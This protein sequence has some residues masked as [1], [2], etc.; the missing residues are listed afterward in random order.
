MHKWI[1]PTLSEVLALSKSTLAN[2]SDKVEGTRV[3][4]NCDNIT[5]PVDSTNQNAVRVEAEME[6]YGAIAATEQLLLQS[7]NLEVLIGNALPP[8]Q[9][10][11]VAGPVP[12]FSHQTLI[13]LPTWL[14]TAESSPKAGILFHLPPATATLKADSPL[15]AITSNAES[16]LPLLAE[17][18]LSNEQFCLVLTAKFSLVMVLGEDVNGMPAF[19][20]SFEPEVVEQ[21]WRLLQARIVLTNPQPLVKLEALVEQYYPVVPDYRTVTQFSRLLLKR[22][23][24]VQDVN[25]SEV[26]LASHT[27]RRESR[28]EVSKQE[29]SLLLAG[30]ST[31][32]YSDELIAPPAF[33]SQDDNSSP[34]PDVEL[35]KA[36]AHEVRTPLTTI[37]T[38]TRLLLKR[39]DLATDVIK[40]L[41]V[42][43]HE[44]TEQIDRMEL[45]FRAAEL[46]TSTVK[47]SSAHLTAMSLEQVLQQ[48]IPRWQQSANRRNLT[49]DVVLPQ[50]LPTVVSDPIMLDQVLTGLI[51]NFTRSLAAGS[52]IQVQVIPAGDQLKLQLLTQAQ[53]GESGMV[54]FPLPPTRKSLGQLLI[55][56]PETG[57]ISLNFAATKHLFQAIGGKLIVR[58]RPHQGEVLTIFL[59]MDVSPADFCHQGKGSIHQ[60]V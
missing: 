15:V 38:L 51:E 58:Q 25:I 12:V 20:F 40:R 6:W 52:H 42:I 14:F 4:R 13:S 48:S 10:L 46:E 45:L 32:S 1:L 21:A 29:D 50:Q 59:P 2:P 31:L 26:A 17:D 9:G 11:V 43:D 28:T 22:L 19:L 24:K 7:I 16:V 53:P 18:P 27:S 33:S 54:E 44:C 34:R 47:H 8:A 5:T 35:L 30:V 23:S 36:F 3:K 41:K 49:L 60:S 56:H 57:N 39:C 37:R 55:F